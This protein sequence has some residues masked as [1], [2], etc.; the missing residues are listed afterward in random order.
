[1]H[2][3]LFLPLLYTGIFGILFFLALLSKKSP[4]AKGRRANNVVC[5]KAFSKG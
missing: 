4:P 3:R 5:Q 2:V 1:M